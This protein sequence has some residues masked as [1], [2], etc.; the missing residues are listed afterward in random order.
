MFRQTCQFWSSPAWY[1]IELKNY[2]DIFNLFL[3]MCEKYSGLKEEDR[4]KI[5]STSYLGKKCFKFMLS[6]PSKSAI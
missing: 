2:Q 3:E 5:V 4:Y 6:I 1:T